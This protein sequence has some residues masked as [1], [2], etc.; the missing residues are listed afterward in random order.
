MPHAD[1]FPKT[2][3]N[4]RRMRASMAEAELKLWNE[5]RAHRL[6]GLCFRRRVPIAGYIDN[7]CKHIVRVIGKGAFE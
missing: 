6:M 3:A 2:R 1:V 7:V 5:S 4:A